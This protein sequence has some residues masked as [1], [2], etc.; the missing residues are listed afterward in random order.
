MGEAPELRGLHQDS[1]T[2]YSYTRGQQQ[3]FLLLRA[4]S[5]WVKGAAMFLASLSCFPLVTAG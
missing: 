1:E 2:S 5:L 4:T 3:S